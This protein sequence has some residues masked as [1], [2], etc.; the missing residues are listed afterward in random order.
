MSH[1][2]HEMSHFYNESWRTYS[3]VMTH[4]FMSHGIHIHESWHTYSWV[5]A[6]IFISHRMHV[7]E[8]WHACT[9][10]HGTCIVM[11]HVFMSHGTRIHESWHTYSSSHFTQSWATAHVFMSHD[12][13]IHES[14]YTRIEPYRSWVLAHI[15]MSLGTR[16]LESWHTYS[17]VIAHIF[18][19][20]TNV[21]CMYVYTYTHTVVCTAQKWRNRTLV[22]NEILVCKSWSIDAYSKNCYRGFTDITVQMT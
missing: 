16:I 14:W 21:Q 15:F 5:M 2:T 11:A 9:S 8:S 18:M 12:K 1:R 10:R 22:G 13:W 7:H 19:S 3:W 17:W 4:V 20:A 6:H